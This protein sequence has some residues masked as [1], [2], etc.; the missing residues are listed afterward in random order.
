MICICGYDLGEPEHGKNWQS[1]EECPNC[2]RKADSIEGAK[3][4]YAERKALLRVAR[5]AK[6]VADDAYYSEE[7]GPH[8]LVDAPFVYDLKE[9]IEGAQHLLEVVK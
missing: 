7:G 1:W 3:R 2:E 6:D 5:A 4:L 9:A 8:Y